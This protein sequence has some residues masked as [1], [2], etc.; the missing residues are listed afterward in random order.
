M[1]QVFR[2]NFYPGCP[3]RNLDAGQRAG[4][5][6][7]VDVWMGELADSDGVALWYSDHNLVRV[8]VPASIGG[9]HRCRHRVSPLARCDGGVDHISTFTGIGVW[10]GPGAGPERQCHQHGRDDE[11]TTRPGT[12]PS[13]AGSSYVPGCRPRARLFTHL[14]SSDR[15]PLAR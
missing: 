10:L 14:G 5:W 6:L 1:L 8:L 15:R 9:P 4:K 12:G 2:A 7:F 13:G 3:G 11:L